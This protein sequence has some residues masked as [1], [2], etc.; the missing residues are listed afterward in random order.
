MCIFVIKVN[1]RS[2]LQDVLYRKEKL[3]QIVFVIADFY[4]CQFLL[5]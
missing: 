5:N 1:V 3:K 2:N 4:F